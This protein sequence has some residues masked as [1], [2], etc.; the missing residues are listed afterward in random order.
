VA[1]EESYGSEDPSVDKSTIGKLI[2]GIEMI[3]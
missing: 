2:K 3:P 1:V